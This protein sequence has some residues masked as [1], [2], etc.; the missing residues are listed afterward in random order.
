MQGFAMVQRQARLRPEFGSLYPGL[1]P[2]EWKPVGEMVSA[3]LASRLLRRRPSGEFLRH[4]CLRD[5]HF[6]FRGGAGRLPDQVE[7]TRVTD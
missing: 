3:V 6:E 7:R 4:R 5:E 2:G 1:K